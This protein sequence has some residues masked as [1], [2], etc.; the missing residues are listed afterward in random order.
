MLKNGW[1]FPYHIEAMD[2]ENMQPPETETDA[3]SRERLS[4]QASG[5]YIKTDTGVMAVIQVRW[6]FAVEGAF[7][8]FSTE[9]IWL[10]LT[11]DGVRAMTQEELQALDT[12]Y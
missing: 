5:S 2:L 10:G 9:Q 4:C 3:E 11:S 6:E 12:F 8:D 1:K 7:D